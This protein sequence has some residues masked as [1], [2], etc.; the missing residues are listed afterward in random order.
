[1]SRSPSAGFILQMKM[2]ARCATP[3]KHAVVYACC[4]SSRPTRLS[5]EIPRTWAPGRNKDAVFAAEG[6]KRAKWTVAA[7]LLVSAHCLAAFHA[8]TIGAQATA[9]TRP[10]RAVTVLFALNFMIGLPAPGLSLTN[11]GGPR[12]DSVRNHF[13]GETGWR[14]DDC[15]V[16]N[17][18]HSLHIPSAHV[19]RRI[20]KRLTATSH[21]CVLSCSLAGQPPVG[22]IETACRYFQ[23]G[24]AQRAYAQD[25]ASGS[26]RFYSSPH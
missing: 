6:K 5:D 4:S 17:T 19:S 13:L 1:M 20:W 7:G 12:S 8:V 26:C 21:D 23:S 22:Q 10:L 14:R 3:F 2:M 9:T 11:L 18:H 16:C 15:S 25:L 24:F